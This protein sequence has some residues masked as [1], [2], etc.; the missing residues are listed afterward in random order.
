MHPFLVIRILAVKAMAGF[1]GGGGWECRVRG[2]AINKRY[3]GCR[4]GN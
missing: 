4:L 3:G 1:S 2:D